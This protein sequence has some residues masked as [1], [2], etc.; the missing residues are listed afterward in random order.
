M[1]GKE[2]E[3]NADSPDFAAQ[4]E[5]AREQLEQLF[6]LYDYEDDVIELRFIGEITEERRRYPFSLFAEPWR[7]LRRHACVRRTRKDRERNEFVAE[8]DEGG[9]ARLVELNQAGYNVYFGANPRRLRVTDR[10]YHGEK[11]DIERVRVCH[12]D[13]DGIEPESVAAVLARSGLTA[14]AIVQTNMQ[15]HGCHPYLAYADSPVILPDDAAAIDR[16]ESMNRR[17]TALFK[18]EAKSDAVHDLS[19]ILRVPGMINWPDQRKRERGRLPSPC[20]LWSC[21]PA[22][23]YAYDELDQVLPPLRRPSVFSMQNDGARPASASVQ[24]S[25][26]LLAPYEGAAATAA[27]TPPACAYGDI[28]PEPESVVQAMEYMRW[29][30]RSDPREARSPMG[31]RNCRDMRLLAHDFSLG[32]ATALAILRERGYAPE[33]D[34]ARWREY[35][36]RYCRSAPGGKV[37]LT[38]SEMLD[39]VFVPPAPGNAETPGTGNGVVPK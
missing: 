1:S 13:L 2:A 39:V 37:P 34:E 18:A 17:L 9:L 32:I 35:L 11:R 16:Y 30:W 29:V 38:E 21:D 31:V 19:R 26:H 3:A 28:V 15:V 5:A 14:S 7:W 33:A 10:C 6:G 23:R 24:D 20:R 36:G 25:G 12:A 8:T 4:C 22:R 27:S